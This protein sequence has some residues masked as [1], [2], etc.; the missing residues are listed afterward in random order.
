ML[1]IFG[2]NFIYVEIFSSKYP[3]K[4]FAFGL[5][6]NEESHLEQNSFTPISTSLLIF[7]VGITSTE[8]IIVYGAEDISFMV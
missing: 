4:Y 5:N 8:S 6:F 3:N 1:I 2:G 7:S